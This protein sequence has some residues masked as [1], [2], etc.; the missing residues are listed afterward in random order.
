VIC[1]IRQQLLIEYRDAATAYAESVRDLVETICRDANAHVEL[2]RRNSR[3]AWDRFEQ[4]TTLV[5]A[6]RSKPHL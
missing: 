1:T 6:A 4:G 5:A 3:N 2:P